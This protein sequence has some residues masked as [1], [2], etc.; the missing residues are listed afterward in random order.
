MAMIGYFLLPEMRRP[1][2]YKSHRNWRKSPRYDFKIPC[3]FTIKGKEGYN[4]CQLIDISIGGAFIRPECTLKKGDRI[5]LHFE[6]PHFSFIV[7]CKIVDEYV[8]SDG[9]GY[10]IKFFPL[11]FGNKN[12]LVRLIKGL[13]HLN[14]A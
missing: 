4:P 8:K 9:T 6:S 5:Q 7:P 14:A 10:G 3:K 11:Q 1:Y 12:G 2:W 13:E